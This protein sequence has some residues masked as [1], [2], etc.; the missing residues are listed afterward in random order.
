MESEINFFFLNYFRQNNI[1]FCADRAMQLNSES[2]KQFSCMSH[3]SEKEH[4][5]YIKD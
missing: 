3:V 1:T 5:I 2:I 4:M